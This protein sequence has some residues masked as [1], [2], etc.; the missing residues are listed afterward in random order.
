MYLKQYPLLKVA[1]KNPRV[2]V[3]MLKNL[4]FF[5]NMQKLY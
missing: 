5:V 4:C 3:K 2:I 1:H